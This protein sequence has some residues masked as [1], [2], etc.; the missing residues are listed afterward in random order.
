MELV[1]LNSERELKLVS[2]ARPVKSEYF[3]ARES[4]NYKMRPI[5]GFHWVGASDVGQQPGQFHW[6]DGTKVDDAWWRS[7]EPNHHGQGKET[8]VLLGDAKLGD[9]P[10]SKPV[11]FVC[12]V[13][14]KFA[15]CF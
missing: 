15:D 11:Y 8:C 9:F 1:K 10:C 6:T 3:G 13:G 2:D 7:G 12:Q 4:G 14:D 5:S